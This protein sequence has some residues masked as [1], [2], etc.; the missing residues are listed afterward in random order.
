MD[1]FI[2]DQR[3]PY[4]PIAVWESR[5]SP[6]AFLLLSATPAV[7]GWLVY[8]GVLDLLALV[9]SRGKGGSGGG[10]NL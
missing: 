1:R 5:K 10:T 8:H 6:L 9:A 4:E 2:T 3:F 7:A